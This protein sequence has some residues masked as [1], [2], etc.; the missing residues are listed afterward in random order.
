MQAVAA[1]N[2][3]YYSPADLRAF[4]LIFDVPVTGSLTQHGPNNPAAPGA[5]GTL[6]IEWLTTSTRAMLPPCATDRVS[7]TVAACLALRW[8]L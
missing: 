3:N 2:G 7:L 6:D 4:Y 8:R 5:E 1:F